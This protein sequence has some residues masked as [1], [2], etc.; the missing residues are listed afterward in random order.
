MTN[1]P[2]RRAATFAAMLALTACASAPPAIS[3]AAETGAETG[4]QPTLVVM[5]VV[6][7][8]REPYLERYGDLVTG[9][10]RRLLDQ[11]RF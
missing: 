8:F 7:Q 9:G 11:G 2:V 3:N 4:R 5:V 6:D 1:Q 10:L